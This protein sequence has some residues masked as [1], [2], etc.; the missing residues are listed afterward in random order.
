ME[1]KKTIIIVLTFLFVFSQTF[2][3]ELISALPVLTS[4]CKYFPIF[5]IEFASLYILSCILFTHDN[6]NF[7]QFL[8]KHPLAYK[9]LDKILIASTII[10][11]FIIIAVLSIP[12]LVSEA[13]INRDERQA[14]KDILNNSI[15]SNKRLP[16]LL[17]FMP[18]ILLCSI[19]SFILYEIADEVFKR[20]YTQFMNLLAAIP[21]LLSV[22]SNIEIPHQATSKA[23]LQDKS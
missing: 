6:E 18:L 17:R 5:Q 23:D 15:E 1:K 19:I 13:G 2:T 21:G 22:L 20:Y 9:I 8:S 7:S 16:I 11:D 10:T 3:W 12:S 14:Y 4:V